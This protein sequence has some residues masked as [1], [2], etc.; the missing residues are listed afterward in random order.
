MST[1]ERSYDDRARSLA[2]PRATATAGSSCIPAGSSL[3]VLGF[4][5]WWPLGLAILAFIFWSRSM[6]CHGGERWQRKMQRM[7]EKMGR[8]RERFGGGGGWGAALERQPRLRR[9]PH[10][11]AAAARRGA[12]RVPRLPRPA[13]L[14]QGQVRVR[15]VHGRAAQPPAAAGLRSRKAD[16]PQRATA[17]RA[18]RRKAGGPMRFGGASAIRC[19]RI[20][21][22]RPGNRS[23]VAIERDP[24]AAPFDRQGG[25]PGVGDVSPAR[26]RLDAK[27]LEDIPVP[28]AGLD[29][30]AMRLREQVV[31][32]TERFRERGRISIAADSS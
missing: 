24:L 19:G 30:F 14:R 29:E 11:D 4:I 10:R 26:V 5:F 18:A 22:F 27:P 7:E 6:G 16:P 12:A 9:V 15:P 23:E 32:E 17:F 21:H 1:A 3:M 2:R 25:I 13:A 28:L 31:A 20:V 8:M